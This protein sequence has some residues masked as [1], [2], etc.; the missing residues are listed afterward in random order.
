[1]QDSIS[2]KVILS[3]SGLRKNFGTTEAVRG[4]SFTISYGEMFGMVGPDGAGKTTTLKAVCGL[5][6][7]SEGQINLFG[8]KV[9]RSGK[10]TQRRIGYLSQRFS[11][12]GDLSVDENLDFFAR[13]HGRKDYK[14]DR[15]S[16]LEMTRLAD[17]T[18]RPAEK[19]SGGMKQKLALACSLIHKP[20]ILIL[21]E[22][23][24]G[25][26]PVSRRDFWMILSQ[27]RQEGLTIIMSTPYL[28]EAERCDRVALFNKGTIL[29]LDNPVRMKETC[30][31][32]V[33]EISTPVIREADDL[34]KSKFPFAPQLYGDRLHII[35]EPGSKIPEQILHLLTEN[36]IIVLSSGYIT[37]SL[38]NI[39]IKSTESEHAG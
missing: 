4:I 20:E 9:I 12:Y 36:G 27:L 24:T 25:V 26:D 21:D 17:F 19:L 31:F 18:T 34:I 1:M 7:P 30:G 35:V 32:R 5:L 37:P 29:K 38:E 2:N 14:K 6:T 13:I 23:T 8:G 33:F 22:P 10:S 39:F 11:L 3:V 15:T 28:D 16:L